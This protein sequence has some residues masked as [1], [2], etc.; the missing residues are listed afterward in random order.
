MSKTA[1]AKLVAV[2][3]TQRTATV[4]VETTAY[5]VDLL[6]EL[7][8]LYK[9]A[10]GN[11]GSSKSSTELEEWYL[12]THGRRFSCPPPVKRSSSTHRPDPRARESLPPESPSLDLHRAPD[13]EPDPEPIPPVPAAAEP[14]PEPE[15]EPEA[16][17]EPEPAPESAFPEEEEPA[18]VVARDVEIELELEPEPEP[19]D[20]QAPEPEPDGDG[21]LPALEVSTAAALR[22]TGAGSVEAIGAP[23]YAGLRARGFGAVLFTGFPPE[24]NLALV[25]KAAAEARVRVLACPALDDGAP[26]ALA[27]DGAYR[28]DPA[29]AQ[30]LRAG[31][32]ARFVAALERGEFAGADAVRLAAAPYALGVALL[33][34]PGLRVLRGEFADADAAVR[35]LLA[36]DAFRNGVFSIPEFT[37]SFGHMAI[38][39]MSTATDRAIVCLNYVNAHAVA[40]VKCPEAPDAVD[41]DK[42]KVFELLSETTY[43]RLPNDLRTLGLHVILHEFEV[44]VFAY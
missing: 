2:Q 13:P 24:G 37:R 22:E 44:Q 7:R 31:E 42:I 32:W 38:W 15:P 6:K 8:G 4:L 20:A 17:P 11:P 5:G 41:T 35:R 30:I 27:P 43:R 10:T 28:Y 21:E 23:Y 29:A 18:A 40:D 3:G 19:E 36:R 39:K 1:P 9:S 33:L 12:A 34:L 25:R 26:C 14:E 16:A